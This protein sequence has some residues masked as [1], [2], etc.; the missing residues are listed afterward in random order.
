LQNVYTEYKGKV[1]CKYLYNLSDDDLYTRMKL[2]AGQ[3]TIVSSVFC[4]TGNNDTHYECYNNGDG[5]Y[6][7]Y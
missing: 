7:D 2:V 6:K 4:V 1:N 3:L 5:L